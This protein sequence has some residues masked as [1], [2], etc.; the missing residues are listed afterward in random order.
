MQPSN[1]A[2][3]LLHGADGSIV[4]GPKNESA[5]DDASDS[6]NARP[7]GT[8]DAAQGQPMG[9]RSLDEKVDENSAGKPASKKT[10]DGEH[11]DTAT[12]SDESPSAGTRRDQGKGWQS[13]HEPTEWK[14]RR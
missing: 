4:D 11:Q 5:V 9:V 6:D 10:D 7:Q 13:K 12:G 8:K 1:S 2:L 3:V 14:S